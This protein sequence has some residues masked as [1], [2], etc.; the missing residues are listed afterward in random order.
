M[1]FF[2]P[3]AIFATALAAPAPERQVAIHAPAAHHNNEGAS[4]HIEVNVYL[5]G[6]DKSILLQPSVI[7]LE[8]NE[9]YSPE[10]STS[11]I[12]VA[13]WGA[14]CYACGSESKNAD[15]TEE[16][17]DSVGGDFSY[18]WG[19]ARYFCA[20]SGDEDEFANSC[21]ERGCSKGIAECPA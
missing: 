20:G 4:P 3:L 15:I 14:R 10:A 16:I 17:C 12:H 7:V 1:R 19:K 8:T 21:Y 5:N 13:S 6:A 11:D 2:I 9:Y 18:C